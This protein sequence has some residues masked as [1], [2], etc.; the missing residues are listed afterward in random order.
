MDNLSPQANILLAYIVVSFI[1]HFIYLLDRRTKKEGLLFTQPP[2][3]KSRIFAF[4][5][6]IVLGGSFIVTW[7]IGYRESY[8]AAILAIA[9]IALIAY[10]LGI[11]RPL[12]QIQITYAQTFHR[13]SFMKRKKIIGISQ[14][15]I[16]EIIS[17]V[18]A[19]GRFVMFEYCIS[20]LVVT[21]DYDSDVFFVEPNEDAQRLG[22]RYILLSFFLGW[23]SI[24]GP[25]NTIRCLITDIRGGKDVTRQVVEWLEW[26]YEQLQQLKA[27]QDQ[28]PNTGST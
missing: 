25:I 11:D 8:E 19:G 6:G 7:V 20:P 3:T 14:M 2:S 24:L 22:L 28:A 5:I 23:F 1:F 21:L 10:S 17:K 15:S 27:Q 16:E 18:G 13:A 9:S 4:L 12:A 26:Y